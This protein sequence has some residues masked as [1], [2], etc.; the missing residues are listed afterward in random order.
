[1]ADT[2]TF[3]PKLSD[4]GKKVLIKFYKENNDKHQ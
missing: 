2:D 3:P 4:E 1:M